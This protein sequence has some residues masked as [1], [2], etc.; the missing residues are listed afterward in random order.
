MSQL[1]CVQ[2]NNSQQFLC[3]AFVP[4]AEACAL[5]VLLHFSSYRSKEDVQRNESCIH[6]FREWHD[7]DQND[8]HVRAMLANMQNI[9]N[10]TEPNLLVTR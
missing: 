5:Q 9:K 3:V 4:S 6:R 10:A 2:M 1:T 7:S 8:P